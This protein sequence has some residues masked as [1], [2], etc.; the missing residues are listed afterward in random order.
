MNFVLVNMLNKFTWYV[1]AVPA[2]MRM[3]YTHIIVNNAHDKCD[4]RLLNT[5]K[6]SVD[7]LNDLKQCRRISGTA[8]VG[9]SCSVQ[10]KLIIMC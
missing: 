9:M 2:F 6:N 5:G 4:S 3:S 8:T 10:H 1:L 7:M